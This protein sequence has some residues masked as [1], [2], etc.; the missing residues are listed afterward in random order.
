KINGNWISSSGIPLPHENPFDLVTI[1]QHIAHHQRPGG[2]NELFGVTMDR[3]FR[4]DFR[5]VFGYELGRALGPRDSKARTAFMKRFVGI[6]LHP[7]MYRDYASTRTITLQPLHFDNFEI[8][9]FEC[10][11]AA[12]ANISEDNVLAHMAS[13]SIPVGWVDHAY[14]Y[15]VN[16]LRAKLAANSMDPDYKKWDESC[17]PYM[18]KNG[19]PPAISELSGWWT[20]TDTDLTRIRYYIR[21]EHDKGETKG[22]DSDLWLNVGID[23]LQDTRDRLDDERHRR[24]VLAAAQARNDLNGYLSTSR[25]KRPQRG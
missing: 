6:L 24:E 17:I 23:P 16:V 25:C 19:I 10:T 14:P 2:T 1:A 20:P 12:A 8:A 9:P 22:L 3:A 18:L 7:G 5:S 21:E 15:V 4:V 11:D 13:N